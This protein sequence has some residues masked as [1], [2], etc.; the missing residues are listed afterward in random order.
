MRKTKD[1]L[2]EAEGRD[3]GKVFV[4]REL[5]ASQ[6]EK[7]AMRA[8]MSAARAGIDIGHVAGMGMQGIAALGIGSLLTA[9]WD[10]AEP[11]L[12]E[13]MACVQI[14]PDP[15][16]P[17]VV[18]PL[19]PM[20]DSEDIEEVATRLLLR[21]EVLELHTGFSLAGAGSNSTSDTPAKT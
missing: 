18:R 10:E 3:K 6:A 15:G 8:L 14:R 7:W 16:N 20:P 21:K 4:I 17:G 11:L 1:V 13:M 9:N 19:N 12:D 2:I 5:P